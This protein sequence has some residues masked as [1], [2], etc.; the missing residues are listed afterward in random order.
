[1]IPRISI[2]DNYLLKFIIQINVIGKMKELPD[3]NITLMCPLA[4]VSASYFFDL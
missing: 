1:M 4:I 2:T 3:L